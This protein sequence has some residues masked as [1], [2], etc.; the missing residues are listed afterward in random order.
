MSKLIKL[1]PETLIDTLI[2][3]RFTTEVP[4]EAIFGLI[5]SSLRDKYNKVINSLPIPMEILSQNKALKYKVTQKMFNESLSL[6]VGPSVIT[7]SCSSEYITWNKFFPSIKE[8]LEK[9]DSLRLFSSIE[10]IGLRYISFFEGH[11][12]FLEKTNININPNIDGYENKDMTFSTYLKGKED[13]DSTLTIRS[14]VGIMKNSE[15]R[16]GGLVDIDIG[17]NLK[18][19]YE[20][21]SLLN[22]IEKAHDEEKGIFLKILKKDFLLEEYDAKFEE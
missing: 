14:N 5:Y 9:I 17:Y 6:G 10:R 11:T 21:N 15:E 7:F 19:D 4:H 12:S 2:E 16:N 20:K 13:F 18:F 8:D 22:L 3:I 1:T